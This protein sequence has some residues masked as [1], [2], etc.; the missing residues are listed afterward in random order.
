MAD[1]FFLCFKPNADGDCSHEIRRL[2]LGRKAMAKLNSVLKSKDIILPA[3]VC[4]VKA[5]VFL[6]DMYNSDSWTIK[7]AER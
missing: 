6:V 1:F 2:L 3:K 4:I 5:M 7:K